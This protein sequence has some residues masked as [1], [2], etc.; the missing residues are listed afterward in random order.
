MGH[1]KSRLTGSVG[2]TKERIAGM[3]DNQLDMYNFSCVRFDEREKKI[4]EIY[5]I[6][7][8]VVRLS[9]LRFLVT[10]APEFRI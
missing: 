5:V 4:V 1:I 7:H 8:I 2:S 6:K 3:V 10:L 9:C